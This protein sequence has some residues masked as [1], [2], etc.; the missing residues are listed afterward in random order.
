MFDPVPPNVSFPDQER[1]L[2]EF[3]RENEIFRRSVDE[4]R[5]GP[6]F[7]FYE[8][9][10]T[11]NGSPHWGSVLTR[12]GKDVFLRYWTMRGYYAPRRS[13]WD[14]HGLPV[15]TEVEKELGIH[16]KRDVENYGIE[17]FTKKCIASVWRYI[18]AWEEMSERVGF[19]LDKDGYATYHRYYVE[20]VWWA[21][22]EFFKK[23]L[24]YQGYKS[25]CAPPAGRSAS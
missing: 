5:G 10:P 15:E 13:G 17:L 23:G 12:V 16:G 20:S 22:S 14:T 3:W 7:T 11:A 19:W 25:V 8:G 4:R 6:R 2:I 1:T 18:G 24:L 9:P 21:L